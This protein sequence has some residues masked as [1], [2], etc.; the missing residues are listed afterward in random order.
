MRKKKYSFRVTIEEFNSVCKNCGV[1]P[2]IHYT[3][4]CDLY[5]TASCFDYKPSDSLEL[6]EWLSL[7]MK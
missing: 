2:S 4:Y 7:K 5:A 1:N 6:L 3:R